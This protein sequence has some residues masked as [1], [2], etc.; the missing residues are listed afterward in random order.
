MLLLVNTQLRSI[1]VVTRVV[2]PRCGQKNSVEFSPLLAECTAAAVL[3]FENSFGF[4]NGVCIFAFY[5]WLWAFPLACERSHLPFLLFVGVPTLF[6]LSLF[7]CLWAFSL[8]PFDWCV[9]LPTRSWALPWAVSG[10]VRFW[11]LGV[12]LVCLYLSRIQFTCIW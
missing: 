5:T 3:V 6:H 12:H 11:G 10:M 9:G 4:N 2:V 1:G 7:A 8:A